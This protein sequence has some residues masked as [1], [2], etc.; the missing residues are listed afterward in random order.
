MF[1]AVS[2]VICS[3][4]MEKQKFEKICERFIQKQCHTLVSYLP[5]LQFTLHNCLRC[6]FTMQFLFI[7]CTVE[8]A[9]PLCLPFPPFP[10]ISICV[11]LYQIMREGRNIK[12]CVNFEL[13]I[14]GTL[15]PLW[16]LQ[17]T[18]VKFGFGGITFFRPSTTSTTPKTIFLFPAQEESRPEFFYFSQ[19]NLPVAYYI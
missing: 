18:C 12:A 16:T 11:R 14:T 10:A 8:N 9:P 13:R 3:R 2:R 4:L 5:A 7:F 6:T 17:F 15:N 19:Y 1:V